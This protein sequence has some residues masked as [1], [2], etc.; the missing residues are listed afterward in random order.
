METK[1]ME[2]N[3]P[4]RFFEK[5]IVFAVEIPIDGSI[6]KRTEAT[7]KP[8]MRGKIKSR[9]KRKRRNNLRENAAS[10]RRRI[11]EEEGVTQ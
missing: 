2:N 10:P 9:K 1:A 8:R 7:M 5:S 11:P 6:E 3:H 4:L